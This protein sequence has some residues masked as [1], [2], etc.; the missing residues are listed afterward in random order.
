MYQRM[1]DEIVVTAPDDGRSGRRRQTRRVGRTWP[2]ALALVLLGLGATGGLI[3]WGIVA[4]DDM[5]SRKPNNPDIARRYG[6]GVAIFNSSGTAE[7]PPEVPIWISNPVSYNDSN[8]AQINYLAKDNQIIMRSGGKDTPLA[9]KGVNWRGMEGWNHV[10][11]G[12]WDGPRDGNTLYRIG[13]FL[14]ANGFNAVRLPLEVYTTAKNEKIAN[15]F[16]TQSQ[17]ALARVNKYIDL[18]GLLAQGLGQFKIAVVLDF[19]TRSIGDINPADRS[20][21]S[22]GQRN[23]SLGSLG[24]GW[25]NDNVRLADYKAA[26]ANLGTALCNSR[27][28]N[29]VGLD[30]KD[31]PAGVTGSWDGDAGTSW[32]QFATEVGNAVLK[33]CPQWLV[34]VQ[35]LT[36]KSKYGDK[37]AEDW[38]GATLR[39]AATSPISLAIPDKVVYAPP[40]WS[41][42]MEP[43]SYFYKSISDAGVVTEFASASEVESAVHGAMDNMFGGVLANTTAPVVLSSFGGLYGTKDAHPLKTSTRAIDAMIRRMTTGTKPLSGGFW[44]ALNPDNVWPFPLPTATTPN[45]S[46]LLDATWRVPN[47]D[48]VKATSFMDAMP[49]LRFLPCD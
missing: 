21:V 24:N 46:G 3:Y 42:S 17:R 8:C 2:G 47:T 4:H 9:F 11:T 36:G 6:S 7:M 29:V 14:A 30:I 33:T 45:V 12:L 48:E 19:D 38:P 16:N 32:S 44:W 31:A 37:T 40:F 26:V 49:N 27:H 13:E 1:P 15:N 25:E 39:D 18:I 34:F 28:W 10:I 5:E 23:S 43:R 35:G 20:V 22:K 41:P